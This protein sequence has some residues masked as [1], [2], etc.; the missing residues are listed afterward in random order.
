V[1]TPGRDLFRV[2]LVNSKPFSTTEYNT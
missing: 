2:I 1:L